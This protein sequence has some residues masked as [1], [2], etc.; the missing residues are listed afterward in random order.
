MNMKFARSRKLRGGLAAVGAMGLLVVMPLMDT[1]AGAQTLPLPADASTT[2]PN[3][4]DVTVGETVALTVDQN[5]NPS[6]FSLYIIN[7][8]V[9]GNGS[10]NLQ[11][12]TGPDKTDSKSL[13]STTGAVSNFMQVPGTFAGTMPLTTKTELK[14]NGQTVNPDQGYNL[15]GDVEITYSVT[16]NT[17]RQQSVTYKDLYGVEQTKIVDVPVPFGDSYSVVFGDGWDITDPGTMTKTTTGAGTSLAATL[18]LF[19]IIQGVVGGTTQSVTVKAKAENASLPNTTHTIVPVKLADYFDGAALKLG[20]A[21]DNKLLSPLDSTLSGAISEVV[22][23]ANIISGYAGGF[24]KLD[25]DFI[26]PLVADVNAIKA[27]PTAIN[28]TLSKLATGLTDLGQVLETN[29]DA[30]DDI[31]ALL[32]A[33]SKVVDKNLEDTV[34]WL[35]ALVTEAGPQ[36][37]KAATGLRSLAKILDDADPATLGPANT[38]MSAVCSSVAPTTALYGPSTSFLGSGPG[39]GA[40]A[41]AAGISATSGADKTNLKSLQTALNNQANGSL[42]MNSSTVWGEIDSLPIPDAAKTLLKG[43]ACAPVTELVDAVVLAAGFAPQLNEAALALDAFSIVA[44]SD[45]AKKV[46]ND[47]LGALTDISGLLSNAKCTDSDILTPIV[48]AIKKYGVDGLEAHAA[49]IVEQIFSK[50][51]LAQVMT[52]FGDFDRALADLLVDLGAIVTDAEKDVPKITNGIKKVQSLATTAGKVFDA[53]PVVGGKVGSAVTEA[54]LGLEGKGDEALAEISGYA[55]LLEATLVAMNDRGVNGDGAPY[56]NAYFENKT[57]GTVKNYT[58]YQ[59]T[60]NGAA[61]YTTNWLT[62][63]G[64]AVVFLVLAVGL[65]TFLYRRRIN[66]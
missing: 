57:E 33:L 51:G 21:L 38:N 49:E 64:I 61:P 50:C 34:E 8:Q 17:S 52:F 43:A 55:G 65:G 56:G 22:L 3:G 47:V 23:A 46:Y 25:A 16:N 20:P 35:G 19:P 4:L 18:V 9:A 13:T 10:G 5:G 39:V 32:T 41:L 6:P 27:D 66:P 40:Q 42:I 2:N 14:V 26:N 59:I 54:A 37:A 12:P 60:V 30:K 48:N 24:A 44:A 36:A 15:N 29:A 63:I 7:G 1:G 62:A 53:I 31:A 45:E 58:A 28:N 11:I